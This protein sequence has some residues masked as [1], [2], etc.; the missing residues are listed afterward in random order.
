MYI[1]VNTTQVASA[2]QLDRILMLIIVVVV[3]LLFLRTI[4]WCCICVTP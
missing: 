3:S 2:K 4:L 1:K